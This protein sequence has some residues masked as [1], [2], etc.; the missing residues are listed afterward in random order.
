ML[1]DIV[2]LLVLVV[3]I[4][5]LF[6]YKKRLDTIH[7]YKQHAK[8]ENLADAALSEDDEIT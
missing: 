2:I 1:I 7:A 6:L 8:H 4:V 3:L 5:A